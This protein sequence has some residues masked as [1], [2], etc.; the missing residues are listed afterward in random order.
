MQVHR[1]TVAV[2]DHD[3]VGLLGCQ[4][5]LEN[6]RYMRITVLDGDTVDWVAEEPPNKKLNQ[7]AELHR[8]FPREAP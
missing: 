1:I 6:S 4:R 8:L 5:I 3:G 7:A 2:I